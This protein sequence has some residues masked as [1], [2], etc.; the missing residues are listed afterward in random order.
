MASMTEKGGEAARHFGGCRPEA[1]MAGVTRRRGCDAV[2]P[3]AGKCETCFAS[4]SSGAAL[5]V[6]VTSRVAKLA[7]LLG[8][9]ASPRYPALR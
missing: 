6:A 5:S 3:A 4:R 8:P 1:V 2:K 9:T 7:T